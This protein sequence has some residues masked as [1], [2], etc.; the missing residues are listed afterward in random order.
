MNTNISGSSPDWPNW[1]GVVPVKTLHL[2]QALWSKRCPIKIALADLG[3]KDT[4]V[5]VGVESED[6]L[7]VDQPVI[8]FHQANGGHQE[9]GLSPQLMDFISYFHCSILGLV[10]K[11][12]PMLQ[13][14]HLVYSI[15]SNRLEIDYQLLEQE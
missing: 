1:P 13:P 15:S 9:Y 10:P 11:I 8:R 14:F 6:P 2:A 12:K 7:F 3:V 5:E 4:E